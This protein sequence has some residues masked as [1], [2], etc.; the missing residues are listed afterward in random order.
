MNQAGVVLNKGDS[1]T[2]SDHKFSLGFDMLLH[3]LCSYT[4]V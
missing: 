1:S 2:K 3:L 4:S